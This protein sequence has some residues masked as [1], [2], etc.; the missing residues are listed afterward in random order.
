MVNVY[1][2]L[3][4]RKPMYRFAPSPTGDMHIGNLRVALFNYLCACKEG[5]SMILRIEDTDQARNIPGKEEEIKEILHIFG[6][7]YDPVFIQSKNLRFHQ[8]MALKLVQEKKAFACFC[9]PKTIA[10]K[11]QAAKENHIPYRYDDTCLHLSDEDV[12]ERKGEFTIRLKRP[13]KDIAF[14]DLIKGKL[15]FAPKEVDSIVIM[16]TDKTPTYNFACTV[17]DMLSDVSCII[18]GEDH[19]SNTPKQEHIKQS[20]GYTKKTLY[21]HLPIILDISGKKMSKRHAHSS[22]KYL[23]KEGFLPSAISNYLLLLGNKTP[24]QIFTLKEAKEWFSLDNI[25]K[26]P[27]KFDIKMLRFINHE[28]LKLLSSKELAHALKIDISYAPLAHFYLEEASTLNELLAKLDILLGKREYAEFEEG[29]KILLPLIKNACK[30]E[31]FDGFKKELLASSCLKGKNFFMPLRLI[32]TGSLNGPELKEL[33]PI[34]R[35]LIINNI[36]LQA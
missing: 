4:Q 33:Y 6:I 10:A 1:L 24:K 18:R 9:T 5:T 2:T 14:T 35:P 36:Y 25:S 3:K 19:V 23:L 22:V 34:L 12:L 27:A 31:D 8:Q 7:S 16:R 11:K 17:D 21:A 30:N 29:V 13:A 26:S 28:H 15:S 32:L 20:L